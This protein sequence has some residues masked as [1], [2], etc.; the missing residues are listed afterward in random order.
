MLQHKYGPLDKSIITDTLIVSNVSND[1]FY[2]THLFVF[3][4]N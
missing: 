2:E 4:T 1:T 3:W